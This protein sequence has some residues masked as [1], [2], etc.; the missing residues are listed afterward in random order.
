[1]DIDIIFGIV[2][3]IF[4]VIIH[5]MAHAYTAYA[6]GD[7]TPQ[8]EGRLTLNPLRHLD[9]MGSVIVPFLCF[10]LGGFIIGWA[11]PVMINPYNFKRF[12][13]WGEALVAA[14][15]PISNILLAT[16]AAL[17][18]RANPTAAF[19][20]PVV[21]KVIV[22]RW[23]AIFNLVPVPPLD[24]SKIL[25]SLLGIHQSRVRFFI[26]RY[27]LFIALAI[28]LFLSDEIGSV[29]LWGTRVLLGV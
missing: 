18:Y 28:L 3:L 24:G 1:M 29:I 25:Y 9:L 13:R 21:T 4:S 12:R 27:G 22:N 10:Q 8:V 19:F 14:A 26:D 5:E 11:K 7:P 20:L 16:L 6:F 15:G 23:L 17:I 2:I